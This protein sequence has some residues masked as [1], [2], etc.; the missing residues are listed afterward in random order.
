MRSAGQPAFESIER[1]SCSTSSPKAFTARCLSPRS[2]AGAQCSP[3]SQD[4]LEEERSDAAHQQRSVV[5]HHDVSTARTVPPDAFF[6]HSEGESSRAGRKHAGYVVKSCFCSQNP[7]RVQTFTDFTIHPD[8]SCPSDVKSY[9]VAMAT[10]EGSERGFQ[11]G[12]L[13]SIISR[14]RLHAGSAFSLKEETN[15]EETLMYLCA[16]EWFWKWKRREGKT[17]KRFYFWLNGAQGTLH[18]ALTDTFVSFSQL[19]LRSIVKV[20]ADSVVHVDNKTIYR[21]TVDGERCLVFGTE[22]RLLF[23]Q[24]FSVLRSIS[25]SNNVLGVPGL[26]KRPSTSAVIREDRWASRYNPLEAL[27]A[28]ESKQRSSQVG[29]WTD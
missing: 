10:Q 27:L 4:V 11:M 14:Y 5:W 6:F 20:S 18:W 16:G 21:M 3:R 25:A 7:F 2:T 26:W 19:R 8:Y 17:Y 15:F 22:N 1:P 28:E 24:W 23:D 29:A 13:A 12:S 9:S